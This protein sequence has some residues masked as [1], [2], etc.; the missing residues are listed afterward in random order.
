MKYVLFCCLILS[1]CASHKYYSSS[2]DIGN[3]AKLT[4]TKIKIIQIPDS[5]F[6][7]A[8]IGVI[9]CLDV[10]NETK[11]RYL[12]ILPKDIGT[13][14]EEIEFDDFYVEYSIPLFEDEAS[15]FI[16]KLNGFLNL[17]ASHSGESSSFEF[18]VSRK[19]DLV[20]VRNNIGFFKQSILFQIDNRDGFNAR[21]IFN[22]D[23]KKLVREIH[24]IDEL[25][26]F[27]KVL[28]DGLN[29]LPKL[30]IEN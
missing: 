30:A 2:A 13:E 18:S 12:L 6:A 8:N 14:G 27:A 29:E 21:I 23:E 5:D 7:I 11:Y 25:D 22:F 28:Q 16:K 1:G 9:A 24:S 10:V 4:E 15:T 3:I 17:K 26:S 20:K 19:H